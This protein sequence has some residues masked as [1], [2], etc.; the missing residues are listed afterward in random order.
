MNWNIL[1]ERFEVIRTAR[2]IVLKITSDNN[3]LSQSCTPVDLLTRSNCSTVYVMSKNVKN[4]L[5]SAF[6]YRK[7]YLE[8]FFTARV[9]E[10]RTNFCILSS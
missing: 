1:N 2:E 3:N 9:M 4:S 10:I 5:P 7:K 8:N 6:T